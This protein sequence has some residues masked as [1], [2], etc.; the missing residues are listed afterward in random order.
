MEEPYRVLRGSSIELDGKTDIAIKSGEL[1]AAS[2][3]SVPMVVA[4]DGLGFEIPA[5]QWRPAASGEW[6]AVFTTPDGLEA[7]ARERMR[8]DVTPDRPPTVEFDRSE[9]ELEVLPEA[10]I[11]LAA[12]ANDDVA[13]RRV[14]LEIYRDELSTDAS[15]LGSVDLFKGSE[16]PQSGEHKLTHQLDLSS[17]EAR[18]G[19]RYIVRAIAEDYA[20]Q[21]SESSHSLRLRVIDQDEF[22]RRI[23]LLLSQLHAALE[24]ALADQRE[25]GQ[26]IDRWPTAGQPGARLEHAAA[27]LSRQRQA[28]ET[29]AGGSRSAIALSKG[30]TTEYRRNQWPDVEAAA[31]IAGILD[32]LERLAANELPVLEGELAALVRDAQTERPADA[33]VSKE[34]LANIRGTQDAVASSLEAAIRDLAQWSEVRQFERELSDLKSQQAA[35]RGRTEK[36]GRGSLEEQTGEAKPEQNRQARQAVDEQRELAARLANAL[37]R[38]RQAADSMAAEKPADAARLDEALSTAIKDSVQ[39]EARAA[40]EHLAAQ[41]FN[42]AAA[43][44]RAT[45][46]ELQQML[47]QLTGR[48][49]AAGKRMADLQQAE[50]RLDAIR[51]ENEALAGQQQQAQQEGAAKPDM[52]Q[53]KSAE[54]ALGEKAERLAERLEKLRAAAAANSTRRA[55]QRLSRRQEGPSN[56]ATQAQRHLK[57]AQ[58]E[59][60]AEKRRQQTAL[61]QRMNGRTDASPGRQ[62]GQQAAK[63]NGRTGPSPA[64]STSAVSGS[65]GNTAD[66]SAIGALVKDLWGK[67]P[68]RQREELLQPLSEEFLPEY[69]AEIEE[70]FRV[71]AE[72]PRTPAAEK[73]P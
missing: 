72:T 18:A 15:A 51:R 54:K 3:S 36:L 7:E 42:Q 41:R 10:R 16:Q 34:E 14:G 33:S 24:R 26:L 13:V 12:S 73:K 22:V 62:A 37:S 61:A 50:Q 19:A 59:L 23:D 30:I 67:L 21:T 38:M 8:I 17:F 58:E 27:T 29:I 9:G 60:A 20:G 11:E 46:T 35:L 39:T 64:Q 49:D 63:S 53:L 28:T 48:E 56:S 57:K 5:D 69:A 45:E 2:R 66:R 70:Y 43:S 44:Q 4:A 32:V 68:E 25:A 1:R 47:D 65:P 52:E 71:L 6:T 55:A 31:R 40:A